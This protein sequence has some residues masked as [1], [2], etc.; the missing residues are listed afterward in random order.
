MTILNQ[1]FKLCKIFSKT[2]TLPSFGDTRGRKCSF[3]RLFTVDL[4]ASS[5][6]SSIYPLINESKNRTNITGIKDS[7][8]ENVAIILKLQNYM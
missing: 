5:T 2:V 7:Y 1:E 3:I 6:I 8:P 4:K